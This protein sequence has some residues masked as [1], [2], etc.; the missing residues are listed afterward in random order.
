VNRREPVDEEEDRHDPSEEGSAKKSHSSRSRSYAVGAARLC[1]EAKES[2][3]MPHCV[4]LEHGNDG[5]KRPFLDAVLYTL[6]LHFF[7]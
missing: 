5:G 2:Y 3:F 4:Q 1:P 6:L 7:L